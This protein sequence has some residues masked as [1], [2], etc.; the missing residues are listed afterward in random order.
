MLVEADTGVILV[1]ARNRAVA[2]N[3][4]GH[5]VTGGKLRHRILHSALAVNR[6]TSAE[7]E[8]SAVMS[9]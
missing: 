3:V 4:V 2:V 9:R 1:G 5:T 7:S 8:A 6:G